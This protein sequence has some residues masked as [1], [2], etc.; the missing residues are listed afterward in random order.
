MIKPKKIKT[1]IALCP[2]CRDASSSFVSTGNDFEFDSAINEFTM[3][4]CKK[5]N[6]FYLKN[7]PKNSE[8]DIIYPSEYY[9]TLSFEKQKSL[10][11]FFRTILLDYIKP[12]PF[13]KIMPAAGNVLDVACGDITFLLRLRKHCSEKVVFWGNEINQ[14]KINELK[15]NNFHTIPGR[16]EDAIIAKKD[17]FEVIFLR[18]IIE[19]VENPGLFLKKCSEIL[20]K[21]GIIVIQTPNIDS[22]TQKLFTKR[23]WFEYHFPRHWVIFNNNSLQALGKEYDLRV[24]KTKYRLSP[25]SWILSIHHLLKDKQYPKWF[26]ELFSLNNLFLMILFT[27][28]DFIQMIFT[29]KTSNMEVYLTKK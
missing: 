25:Y 20:S 21:N 23:H 27:I 29:R 11:L 2:I 12:S 4:Q 16:F 10:P 6:I 17:K 24:I 5:C 28:I 19:H 22:F 18:N 14:E 26:Y 9:N 13:L 1:V 3:V 7:R 15:R 8:L